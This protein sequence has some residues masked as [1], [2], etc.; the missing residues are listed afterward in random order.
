MRPAT[1]PASTTRH[2][3]IVLIVAVFWVA[4]GCNG[5]SPAASGPDTGLRIADGGSTPNGSNGVAPPPTGSTSALGS[6]R[7]SCAAAAVRRGRLTARGGRPSR[8]WSESA[9]WPTTRAAD[10][11]P[12]LVVSSRLCGERTRFR[13]T[14]GQ[15]DSAALLPLPITGQRVARATPAIGVDPACGATTELGFS[16]RPR[17][18]FREHGVSSPDR[19]GRKSQYSGCL[20]DPGCNE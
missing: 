17:S 5:N 19:P 12:R 2:S 4:L 14:R 11:E 10:R 3:L 16:E 7:A 8:S 6:G 18:P 15:S 13:H 20:H 1:H 9:A